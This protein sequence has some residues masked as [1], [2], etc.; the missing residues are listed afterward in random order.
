MSAKGACSTPFAG[1]N[2]CGLDRSDVLSLGAFLA[3]TYIKLNR[4]A[5]NEG[6]EAVTGDGTEV[7]EQVGTTITLDE[8]IALGLV[9]PLYSAFLTI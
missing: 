1:L 5:L 6:A 7:D 2:Q 4:L 8:T 3:F 9:E